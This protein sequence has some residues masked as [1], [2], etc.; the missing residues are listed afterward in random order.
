MT[1]SKQEVREQQVAV[2]DD[3]ALDNV[4]LWIRPGAWVSIM[5]ADPEF[6]GQIVAIT[7]SHYYLRDASWIPEKGRFSEYAKNPQQAI[8][9]GSVTESEY[10]GDIAIERPVVSI[11]RSPTPGK[12]PT[13]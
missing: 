10:L 2:S 13:K 8:A 12:I 7:P 6:F 4:E 11:M 9:S 5:C 1:K 3:A